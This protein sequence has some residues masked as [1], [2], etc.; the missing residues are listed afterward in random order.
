MPKISSN[1]AYQDGTKTSGFRSYELTEFNAKTVLSSDHCP[2]ILKDGHRNNA[3]FVSTD[4]LWLDCDGGYTIKDFQENPDFRNVAYILYTSRNHNKEKASTHRGVP[5]TLPACERFHILFPVQTITNIAEV[6]QKI[7]AMVAR[8]PWADPGAKG[9]SRLLYGHKGTTVIWHNGLEYCPPVDPVFEDDMPDDIVVQAPKTMAKS[10]K[11]S[12]PVIV[13][14]KQKMIM[15]SLRKAAMDGVFD[16]YAEWIKLGG[17]MRAEGYSFDQWL[18]LSFSSQDVGEARYKWDS[19]EAMDKLSGGT[20]MHYARMATPEL[21][22]KGSLPP[23]PSIRIS[24]PRIDGYSTEAP[25]L[26]EI[27]PRPER[28]KAVYDEISYISKKDGKEVRVLCEDWYIRLVEIDREIANC[29]KYD[30]TIGGP[31]I[32]YS[33]TTLLKT[34]IRR[35]VRCY[36]VAEKKITTEVI[37]RMYQEIMFNNRFHNRVLAFVKMLQ[38]KY[39]GS[40]ALGPE[41]VD[42]FLE[43]LQFQPIH[44]YTTDKIKAM[45]RET[46]HLFFLRMHLH[47]AG[48]AMVEDG[49]FRGLITNDIV[50]VLGGKQN[51]G[52]TTLCQWLACNREDM[53]VDLGSGGKTGFGTADTIRQVRGR[54]I[55]EL[56]EMK[57]MR[58]SANVEAVKSFISKTKYELDVKYVE[59]S[60]PLPSTVSYIGT[61]NPEEYLS[62]VTGNRRFYPIKLESIDKQGL[63]GAWELIEQ[64]HAYY[65]NLSDS[66]EGNNRFAACQPSDELMDFMNDS[67]DSA[68][69]TYADHGAIVEVVE[70]DFLRELMDNTK[71]DGVHKLQDHEIHKLIDDEGYKMMIGKNSIIQ[72]MEGLGYKKIIGKRDGKMIRCWGKRLR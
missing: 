51:I 16:D 9:A 55:A 25:T 67:R 12:A 8:Y 39:S 56:G 17:A 18:S 33:D 44:G 43:Y 34:A 45:Y 28:C 57:I 4:W 3:S 5:V 71:A 22:Q 47:I 20:L 54:M 26:L 46:F 7:N 27:V 10:K 15:D 65:A 23:S 36:G 50:P 37:D 11:P 30:Y 69:I 53:Y 6:D 38:K 61:S 62:D 68:M 19:F 40:A 32:S 21:L 72:A 70:K 41:L 48:T 52:K 42:R 63:A 49:G 60:E 24:P 14:D 35:R 29:A 1:G 64:I 2:A 66:I 59:H 31:M 13:D 58:D